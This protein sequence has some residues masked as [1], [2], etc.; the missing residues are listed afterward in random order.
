MT[1]KPAIKY[2]PRQLILMGIALALLIGVFFWSR[3]GPSA[4]PRGFVSHAMLGEA[5]PLTVESGTLRCIDKTMVIIDAA[6]GTTYAVN[7]TALG[8][9][10]ASA[11]RR[12]PD[13][14]QLAVPIEGSPGAIKDLT[15]LLRAGLALC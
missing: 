1:T 5:W 12:W 7:G 15:P 10:K 14:K 8:A 6:D 4:P 11:D 3:S 13:V 9:K 2:A